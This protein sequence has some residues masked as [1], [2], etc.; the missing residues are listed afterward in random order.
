MA[1][2]VGM[3]AITLKLVELEELV[4]LQEAHQT[5]E[6]PM[7]TLEFPVHLQPVQM[8]VHANPKKQMK[9]CCCD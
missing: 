2:M 9:A 8:Y 4:D 1:V 7:E 3:E 5:R 6:D